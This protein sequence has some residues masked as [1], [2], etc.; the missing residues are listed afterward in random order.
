M[1]YIFLCCGPLSEDTV[2]VWELLRKSFQFKPSFICG[3]FNRTPNLLSS[4][5]IIRPN[6]TNFN[7]M[8]LFWYCFYLHSVCWG[9]SLFRYDS[10]QPALLKA[11][12]VLV[13]VILFDF[14]DPTVEPDLSCHFKPSKDMVVVLCSF[15]DLSIT[16][17][18]SWFIWRQKKKK[19]FYQQENMPGHSLADLFEMLSGLRRKRRAGQ[20]FRWGSNLAW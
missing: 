2:V 14:I 11:M 8:T 5:Y 1:I 6:E 15:Q 4:H 19:N 17:I 18:K 3:R 10:A 12:A 9:P 20:G 13:C 16:S 7:N